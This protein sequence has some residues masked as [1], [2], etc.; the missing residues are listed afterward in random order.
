MSVKVVDLCHT[1]GENSIFEFKALNNI[2]FEVKSGELIGIIG[3]TGSGKSTLIQHINRLLTPT[4]GEI[5][6]DELNINEKGVLM[7]D[8]CSKVGLVFQYPEYQLFEETVY[9][10][11]AFGPKNI[12]MEDIDGS[13]KKSMAM[14]GLDFETYKD[15]SPFELS[16]GQKR[17]VA[18]AGVIAMDPDI[19]ILDEPASGLDPVG[20]KEILDNIYKLHKDNNLTTFLV[21]HSMTDVCEYASKIMVYSHG[22]LKLFDESKEVFKEVELLKEIGLSIPEGKELMLKL[23]EKGLDANTDLF[24]FEDVV[25]EIDNLI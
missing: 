16:G 15:K 20:R 13:V 5:Y 4:S 11:I 9:K 17:R 6:L 10:D 22:E 24:T 14:V 18:I 12:G 8:I 2:N 3:H 1:Y 21:S 19:L 25:K 7:K 23:K